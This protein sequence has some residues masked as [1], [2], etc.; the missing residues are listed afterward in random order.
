MLRVL[1]TDVSVAIFATEDDKL[2]DTIS[3]IGVAPIMHAH[4]I[5]SNIQGRS[6]NVVYHKELLL[7]KRI[8]PPGSQFFS[9]KRSSHFV[10]G[11][12]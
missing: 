12:K 3:N 8:R 6:F 5:N 4:N 10:K 2:Q 11:S 7:K 1:K 9:F